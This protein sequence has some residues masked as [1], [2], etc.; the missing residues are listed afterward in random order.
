[1]ENPLNQVLTVNE[2]A[3]I[4][5]VKPGTIKRCCLGQHGLPPRF[6]PDEFRKSGKFWLITRKGMDRLF[7]KS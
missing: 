6:A 3:E 5:G 4:Y 1:M 2:A 7:K